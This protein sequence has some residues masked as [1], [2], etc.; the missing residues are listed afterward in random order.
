VGERHDPGQR[1][2]DHYTLNELSDY[3][4][5]QYILVHAGRSDAHRGDR[6]AVPL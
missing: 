4:L 6:P 3:G 2:G 1:F 5:Q